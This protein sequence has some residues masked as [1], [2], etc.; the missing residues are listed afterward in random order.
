MLY[1]ELISEIADR[2]NLKKS[3]AK[4]VVEAM[5]DIVAEAAK[6]G[7][8]VAV[9][10]LGTFKVSNAAGREVQNPHNPSEKISVPEHRSLRLKVSTTLKKAIN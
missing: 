10:G 2:T 4:A 6:S 8:N 3:D 7:E 1:S 9:S 5:V